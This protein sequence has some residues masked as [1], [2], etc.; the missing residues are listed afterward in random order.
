MSEWAT[1]T[2]P[3]PGWLAPLAQALDVQPTRLML[4]FHR[5]CLK[6]EADRMP[7]RIYRQLTRRKRA[8]NWRG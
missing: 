3:P 8:K 7:E 5:C 4:A 6:D 2:L 1:I